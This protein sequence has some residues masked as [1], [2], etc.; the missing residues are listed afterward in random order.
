M[1][2]FATDEKETYKNL[3]EMVED[4]WKDHN[5]ECLNPT[6]V[7][8]LLIEKIVNFSRVIEELYKYTDT[9]TDSQTTTKDNVY[10]LLVESVI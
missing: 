6:K 4:A 1:K 2:E 10:M 7:P 8:R 9:Y 3:M 5:K